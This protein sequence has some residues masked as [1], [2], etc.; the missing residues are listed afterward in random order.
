MRLRGPRREH[1]SLGRWRH[2][3]RSSR[4]PCGNRISV[5]HVRP[6]AR[7]PDGPPGRRPQAAFLPDRARRGP[8]GRRRMTPLAMPGEGDRAESRAHGRRREA[9]GRLKCMSQK[10]SERRDERASEEG[11]L[12]G[13]QPHG[14]AARAGLE[15]GRS[16]DAS[17]GSSDRTAA[18]TGT[19]FSR[20][21][22]T[23]SRQPL[24]APRIHRR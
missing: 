15:L 8:R 24:A 4:A 5:L 3:T 22:C 16:S 13:T 19:M 18:F 17:M 21:C 1:T 6:Q 11:C 20:S 2:K 12:H 23:A 9:A 10:S 7:P 14:P